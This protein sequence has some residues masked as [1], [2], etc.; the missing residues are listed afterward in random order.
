MKNKIH[1]ICGPT[2][3]GKSQYALTLADTL[4]TSIINA[5]SMQIYHG[6]EIVTAQPSINDRASLPHHLYGHITC[7]S[8]YSVGIWLQEV[9]PIID[10][11][12]SQDKH[13]IIVGGTGMYINA[14]VHGIACI[15]E[16]SLTTKEMVQAMLTSSSIESLHD[17]L[18]R[19]DHALAARLFK[20]DSQ[21][22]IRGLEV[23][24]QT[25]VP[26]SHWQQCKSHF[27]Q[28]DQFELILIN[29]PREQLYHRINNRFLLM[30]EAGLLEEVH[31]IMIQHN[32]ELL[33]KAIGLHQMIDYIDGL[34]TLEEAINKGQQFTRNYAKRQ[35]TWFN[36]QLDYDRIITHI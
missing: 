26:L 22:I 28:R 11:L 3:S 31:R 12:L 5:D 15:P 2:A 25:G 6:L 27:Y 36:N 4:Q 30:L 14:L 19:V 7:G 35:I 17:E 29:P 18:L 16:V 21:R 13:V 34:I 33:P 32:K 10:S 24:Y 20:T 1:I 8:D 23:Y 9:R